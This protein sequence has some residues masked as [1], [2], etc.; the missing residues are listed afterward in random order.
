MYLQ[1]WTDGGDIIRHYDSL[2]FSICLFLLLSP[3]SKDAGVALQPKSSMPGNGTQ[4]DTLHEL[5]L[6]PGKHFVQRNDCEH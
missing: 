1:N 2:F 4:L 3:A 5:V 6:V